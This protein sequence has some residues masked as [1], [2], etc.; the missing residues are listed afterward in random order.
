MIKQLVALSI[1]LSFAFVSFA[2]DE[3]KPEKIK[4]ISRAVEG[5]IRTLYNDTLYGKIQV[6][7]AQDYYITSI[8]FKQKGK[9]EVVYSAYDIKRF[10]QIVPFPDRADFGVEEVYFKSAENPSDAYKKVFL[11]LDEWK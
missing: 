5:E 9:K 3:D 8:T 4:V 11:P 2:Q 10:K 1:F 6:R 7:D